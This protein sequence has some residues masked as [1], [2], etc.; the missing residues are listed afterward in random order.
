MAD[1]ARVPAVILAA[2]GSMRLGQPK[3]LLRLRQLDKET[4]LDRAVTLAA[5]AGADPIFVVLG[6]NADEIERGCLLEHCT[7]LRNADWAEGMASSLRLGISAIAE[8]FP[9]ASGALLMVCDQPALSREHLRRLLDMHGSEPES[10]AASRYAGRPGVPAI[11]PRA[12]FPR[13][14]TLTGDRGA[15]AIF[16]HAGLRINETEFPGGEWD[17]DSPKDIERF[18]LG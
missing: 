3:Q 8:Q 10:V 5:E 16:D 18:R 4:L 12:L 13:L 14:L 11:V 17:I 1:S 7:V 2:G 9:N 6:A 15:R